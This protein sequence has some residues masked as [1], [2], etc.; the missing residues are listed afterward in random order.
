MMNKANRYSTLGVDRLKKRYAEV[1]MSLALTHT[2]WTFIKVYFLRI[3]FLDG[4][5]GFIIAIGH[6][7]DAFYRYAKFYEK[8]KLKEIYSVE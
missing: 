3:G 8:E 7:Y 5:P 4:W 2:V 1:S 6:S